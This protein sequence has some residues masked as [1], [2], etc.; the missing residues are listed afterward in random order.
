M[1]SGL[2]DLTSNVSSL[3]MH[4][5]NIWSNK[6]KTHRFLLRTPPEKLSLR[7]VCACFDRAVYSKMYLYNPILRCRIHKRVSLDQVVN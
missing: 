5:Y 7:L 1:N 2:S 3:N 6:M 4:V